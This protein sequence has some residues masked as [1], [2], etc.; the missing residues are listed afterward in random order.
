MATNAWV[1]WS[2]LPDDVLER[3]TLFASK[4][5]YSYGH[6]YNDWFEHYSREPVGYNN[7]YY[8]DPWNRPVGHEARH[9][10]R[11]TFTRWATPADAARQ[12]DA[13]A[14]A[15]RDEFFTYGNDG[16]QG[17][18]S[19]EVFHPV[20]GAWDYQTPR[21]RAWNYGT[22]LLKMVVG[23]GI[24]GAAYRQVDAKYP[25]GNY[26]PFTDSADIAMYRAEDNGKR[27]A[28]AVVQQSVPE[29]PK[30]VETMSMAPSPIG[31]TTP[32]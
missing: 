32:R 14:R 22:N 28:K 5:K 11:H 24:S 13:A 31:D 10:G 9:Q 25:T 27:P 12:A 23:A 4:G 21:E 29:T 8:G 20:T 1:D 19:H 15:F 2:R 6:T 18:A 26:A 3:I 16:Y 30:G 17:S 7:P